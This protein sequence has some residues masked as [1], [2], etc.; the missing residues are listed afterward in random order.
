MDKTHRSGL[1][2]SIKDLGGLLVYEATQTF[3][4]KAE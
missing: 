4:S 3:L 1:S 2:R